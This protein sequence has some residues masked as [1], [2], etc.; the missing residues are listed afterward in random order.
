MLV[1]RFYEQL[2]MESGIDTHDPP[3]NQ[4]LLPPGFLKESDSLS[5]CEHSSFATI[6]TSS[7]LGSILSQEIIKGISSVGQ[8]GYNVFVF[9][10]HDLV[11]K[12]I[13]IAA[14]K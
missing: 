4:P 8:P 3:A 6:T 9:S 13:P 14:I 11:A 10:A 12:A 2:A 7:I 5:I 1:H